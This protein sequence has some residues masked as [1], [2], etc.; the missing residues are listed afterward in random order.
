MGGYIKLI[1]LKVKEGGKIMNKKK[2]NNMNSEIEDDSTSI[3][4]FDIEINKTDAQRI[5]SLVD[6]YESKIMTHI[7][8]EY[9]MRTTRTDRL[10][11][12]IFLLNLVGVGN[13]LFGLG[14]SFSFGSFGIRLRLPSIYI[15]MNHLL[16]Y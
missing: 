10:V 7:D 4:G 8:E 9:V 16:S 13:L 6:N 12:R 15:S 5:D 3:Q 1:F 2:V 14:Y 11:Q